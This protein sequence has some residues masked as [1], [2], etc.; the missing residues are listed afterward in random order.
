MST[1]GHFINTLPVMTVISGSKTMS[2]RNLFY[3]TLILFLSFTQS[4]AAAV[5]KITVAV[6]IL[7]QAY[8]V[9]RIGG[10]YVDVKVMIPK[11]ISPETFEPTPQQLISL[12]KAKIYVNIGRNDFPAENK[13]LKILSSKKNRPETVS[14]SVNSRG[15]HVDPHVW[16]S[17]VAVKQL[18][19]NITGALI[20]IDPA[21]KTYYQRN[22]VSFLE[23]IDQMDREIK[24]VLAGKEGKTFLVYHPAWGYFA[25]EYGLNQLAVEEE[26]KPV[27]LTHMRSIIDIARK[28]GLNIIFVQK[29]FDLRSARAVAAEI[30]AKIIETDPLEKEW[31]SNLKN[32]AKLLR[33]ALK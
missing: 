20:H 15:N 16:V 11:G 12:S 14:M 25:A 13:F 19:Q 3:F 31:L 28:K 21:H 5:E 7:P 1:H 9:E 8:F 10:N 24:T 6:T 27:N 32:F 30:D 33:M 18:S 29:A 22:L 4:N 2:L 26:G 23:D 17:P